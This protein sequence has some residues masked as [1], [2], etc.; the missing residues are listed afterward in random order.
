MYHNFAEL[1]SL[2]ESKQVPLYEI[3]LENEM[4]L[5][6]KSGQEIYNEVKVRYGVMQNAGL[7]A[8]QKKLQTKGSLIEGN[9]YRH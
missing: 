3:I 1:L 8:L 6:G 5:T 7:K 4:Q 9:A 2:C